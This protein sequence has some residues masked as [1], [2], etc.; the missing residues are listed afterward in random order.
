MICFVRHTRYLAAAVFSM[1]LG[2]AS[3]SETTFVHPG[4]L[5]TQADFDRMQVNVDQG[6]QPW[7]DG[8]N[9]LIV[10]PHAAL[11]WK[12]RPVAIVYRGKDGA[13]HAE[14]YSTLFIMAPR[15][16]TTGQTGIW[17]TWTR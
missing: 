2:I 1:T 10:N 13:G 16:T 8:W 4:A 15:S 11:N 17:P 12:P 7:R 3:A 14:N 5:H 6:T 9:R